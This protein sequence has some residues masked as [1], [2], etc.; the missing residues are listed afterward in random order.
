MAKQRQN[1]VTDAQILSVYGECKS[2]YK[3]AAVLG[4]GDTTVYRVLLK[5]GV[6]RTGLAEFREKITRFR[7]QEEQ[8]RAWYD[9]GETLD[10]NSR[11]SGRRIG[12]FHQTRN[13][14][15][16]RDSRDNPA[17]TT[18]PGELQMIKQL[19]SDGLGQTEIALQLGRSQS[20]VSRA[21]RREGIS[22][23]ELKGPAHP[24]WKGG[25]WK[26][27]NGYIRA[28][29]APDDPLAVMRDRAGYVL[30]H[31]VVM[32]RSLGRPLSSSESVHHINAVRDDNRL[33][34]LQ[35]RAGRHGNGAAMVCL[36]CGSHNVGHAELG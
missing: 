24:M 12:L 6:E 7:G 25:R 11:S 29:V 1:P 23:H 3:T 31:R 26:D 36:D 10:Q 30:E 8:L 27:G 17:P 35:L 20:F 19:H 32:A 22:K 28:W 2:A 16:R 34:N 15:G 13:P 21:M 4:I 5:N 9:A 14:P 33:E 18:K